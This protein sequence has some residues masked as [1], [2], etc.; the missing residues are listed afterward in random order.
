M[1]KQLL[2]LAFPLL[3]T[4]CEQVVDVPEPD[5]TPALALRYTLPTLAPPDTAW[6]AFTA[7]QQLYISTSRRLFDQRPLLGLAT[8]TARLLT[9]DGTVVEEFQPAAP[10]QRYYLGSSDTAGYYRPTRGF[11]AQPGGSYRLQV[12]AAGYA[13]VESRLTL[14]PAAP[15]ITAA[16]FA[17]S[18]G[19]SEYSRKGRLTL[20]VQD[21]PATA[22]YYVAYARL[23]DDQGQPLPNGY[24]SRNYDDN[25]DS[26]TDFNGGR[27]LLSFPGS[28]SELYPFA[29]AQVAGT[30]FSLTAE[31]Q[32]SAYDPRTGQALIGGQLEV[33]VARITRDAYEH[34]LSRRRYY[35]ASGNPFAEPAPLYSNI[36]NG[37]G[38]FGGAVET[39]VRI[40]L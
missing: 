31:V 2:L 26:D 30:A 21:D 6:R 22:D 36:T 8:A 38:L 28:N 37:Y 19:S 17:P 18:A 14:P 39:S 24:V 1:K 20:T 33:T 5:H 25:T 27:F 35:D 11:V 7:Y 10:Y 29:D 4:A 16:A 3:F 12:S 32:L 15:T 40:G 9:D 23:L 34:Y 13:T